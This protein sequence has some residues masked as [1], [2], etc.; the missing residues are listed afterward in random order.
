[1]TSCLEIVTS[2]LGVG[3]PDDDCVMMHTPDDE[4]V[5]HTPDNESVMHT[6]DDES[7]MHT[8]DDESVMCWFLCQIWL[9]D[10]PVAEN[11][12]PNDVAFLCA[13]H[14]EVAG[15]LAAFFI[16]PDDVLITPGGDRYVVCLSV[17]LS[18]CL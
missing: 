11:L 6:P 7:V 4:S 5:M 10:V 8:P 3:T 18:V 9:Y 13:K 15:A 17:F 16:L 12:L 1:M 2:S 14:A